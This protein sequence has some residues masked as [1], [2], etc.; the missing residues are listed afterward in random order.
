MIIRNLDTSGDW[1]F[2]H[3]QQD[4]LTAEAA[5][6]LNAKTRLKCF[7]N[8]AFW[9]VDFGID[10]YALLGTR[11]A[12]ARSMIV[13][14]TRAVLADSF[15][16]VRINAVT[17]SVDAFRKLTINYNVDTIYTR[18]VGGSTQPA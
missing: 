9:D 18:S 15:G 11:S 16:I 8:D 12:A 2:G 5:V 4:Y 7:K 1:V 6:E 14:A 13:L 10:W 17:T 3:G